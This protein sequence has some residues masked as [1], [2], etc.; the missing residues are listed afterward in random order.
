[1]SRIIQTAGSPTTQRNRLRR[2]IAEA[3]RRLME[4]PAFD[5]ESRDLTALIVFSLREIATNI[6]QS[7]EAWE[8]RDYYI[9]ADRFRREWEWVGPMERLLAT[10]LLYDQQDELP[11]LFA[12]LVAR[13]QDVSVNKLTRGSRLWEGAYERLRA[14]QKGR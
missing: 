12:Q 9:K 8:K 2:T 6:N 3:L 4:K 5:A 10:A 13:F 7:A 11:L 14:E 1:L